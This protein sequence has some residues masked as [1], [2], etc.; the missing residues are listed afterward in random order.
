MEQGYN[1]LVRLQNQER[2]KASQIE[3]A[4]QE[5]L[6]KWRNKSTDTAYNNL[7]KSSARLRDQST[8]MKDTHR[9]GRVKYLSYKGKT[10]H[11]Y[12]T[13]DLMRTN[14]QGTYEQ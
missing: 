9:F 11:K 8:T 13:D 1:V 6:S 10:Q 2:D 5:S 3:I 4:K 7:Y 12:A 14:Y